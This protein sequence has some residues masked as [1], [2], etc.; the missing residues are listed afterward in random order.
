MR[1][2]DLL[3]LYPKL[4]HMAAKGSWPSIERLG[5]LSTSELTKQ[6]AVAPPALRERLL[7]QRRSTSV[8]VNSP[9]LGAA[10][11]RDQLPLDERS[12]SLALVNM[13]AHDWYE[14]LNDR[15]F[16]FLQPERLRTLLNARSYRSEEQVVITVD[17]KSFL[18]AHEPEIELCRINS[19]FAQPHNHVSRGLDTFKSIDAYP[20][21]TRSAPRTSAPWDVAEL[22]VQGAVLDLA[23]H[24][25]SVERVQGDQILERIR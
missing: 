22:C 16:F 18:R 19:G 20:H 24:V 8:T 1:T 2:E 13:K 25:L 7:G 4:Y 11:I 3:N 21:P 5:L 10:T 14:M 6:W 15:V 23:Q 9:T 17:T 12:L